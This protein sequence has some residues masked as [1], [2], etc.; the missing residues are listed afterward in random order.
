[1]PARP[2]HPK[3]EQK[4]SLRDKTRKTNNAEAPAP[5]RHRETLHFPVSF[6]FSSPIPSILSNSTRGPLRPAQNSFPACSFFRRGSPALSLVLL[7]R[8][9]AAPAG[10]PLLGYGRE[11]LSLKKRSPAALLCQEDKSVLPQS[12]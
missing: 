4:P 9:R 5:R 3:N 1:M 11:T 8:F 7:I 6:L 10:C 12:E 2:T